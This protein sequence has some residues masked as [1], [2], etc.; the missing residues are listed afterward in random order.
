MPDA[1][2]V[3]FL[4][5]GLGAAPGWL[6]M[7]RGQPL[8]MGVGL[9]LSSHPPHGPVLAEGSVP[10]TPHSGPWGR[11]DRSLGLEG[12]EQRG[13]EQSWIRFSSRHCCLAG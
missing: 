2:T 9:L 13:L 10:E 5:W 6:G 1:K 8:G 3:L 12:L 4:S 7:A 11:P